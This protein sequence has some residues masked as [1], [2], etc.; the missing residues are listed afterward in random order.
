MKLSENGYQNIKK[1][2]GV[3]NYTYLDSRNIPTIGIGFITVGGKKVEMGMHM[4]DSDIEME[5]LKQI[6]KYEDAVNNYVTSKI[7]QNQFDA[8]VSFSY[9]LGINS[10]KTS[11]LLKKININPS[12]LTIK[13][14]FQKWNKAGGKIIEGLTN[15]RIAEE[16]LYF[17]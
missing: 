9:N 10:L 14:E 7:N 15:R 5:F 4:S 16:K 17:S 12:D 11:T 3:K 8:L 13:L 1:F 2:E 6:T